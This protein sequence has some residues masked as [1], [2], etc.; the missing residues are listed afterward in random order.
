ME[1]DRAN[2]SMPTMSDTVA[3]QF[4]ALILTPT[5]QEPTAKALD[6]EEDNDNLD[7]AVR[8]PQSPRKPKSK[9]GRM[10]QATAELSHKFPPPATHLTRE[11]QAFTTAFKLGVLSNAT[12]GRI[13]DGKGGLRTPTAMEVCKRYN[14][15]HTRYLC[16]WRQEEERLL[17]MKPSQKR[18]RPSRG[19]WPKLEKALVQAF[20]GRHAEGKTVERKLF[21]RTAKA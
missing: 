17:L 12:Y 14:L 18:Y 4:T 10:R 3:L 15:K 13:E 5:G 16:R 11:K 2:F 6:E 9:P 21:E 8:P 20:A 7:V 1:S 19:H